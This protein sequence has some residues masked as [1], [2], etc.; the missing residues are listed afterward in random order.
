MITQFQIIGLG[1]ALMSQTPR[2]TVALTLL[3]EARGETPVGMYAVACVIRNRSIERKMPMD[4]V[5]T[6]KY[7][8]SCWPA[9]R[10]RR[11]LLKTKEGKFAL[12]ITDK[13]MS[14][15]G[16]D[17]TGGA[18]HYHAF[19]VNPSWKNGMKKTLVYRSHIFY[20]G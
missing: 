19:Y 16:D 9:I 6:Q 10:S 15:Q 13:I 4:K 14:G 12:Q 11:D 1:I 18:N 8:F 7:Q 17:I 5:C 20:R 2:E 3:G